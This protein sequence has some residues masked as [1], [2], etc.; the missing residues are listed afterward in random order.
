MIACAIGNGAEFTESCVLEIRGDG[1]MVLHQ[2]GGGFRRVRRTGDGIESADGAERIVGLAGGSEAF[3]EFA[4]GH[5]RY[6]IPA[7]FGIAV[8]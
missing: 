4:I 6:R 5:D 3:T 1:V 2:P 8:E 7:R